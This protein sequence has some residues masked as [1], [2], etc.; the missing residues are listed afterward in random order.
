LSLSVRHA[1]TASG[2]PASLEPAVETQRLLDETLVFHCLASMK[3]LCL[4]GLFRR[5][6]ARKFITSP[7][8]FQLHRPPPRLQFV[9]SNRVMVNPQLLYAHTVKYK[10]STV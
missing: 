3:M 2:S 9:A 4:N 1:T 7:L 8:S 10:Q 6:E 5:L